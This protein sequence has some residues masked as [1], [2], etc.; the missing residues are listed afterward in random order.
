MLMPVYV[1]L[2][3]RVWHKLPNPVYLLTK[4]REFMYEV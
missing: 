2:I 3:Q 1:V 4:I